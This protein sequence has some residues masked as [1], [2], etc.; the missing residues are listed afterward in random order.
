VIFVLFFFIYRVYVQVRG[1]RPLHDQRPHDEAAD[2][3]AAPTVLGLVAASLNTQLVH[4]YQTTTQPGAAAAF[5]DADANGDKEEEGE[6]EEDEAAAAAAAGEN[7]NAAAGNTPVA[8]ATT[9]TRGKVS[10]SALPAERRTAAATA[11]V[12][13]GRTG[14]LL[15]V[16]GAKGSSLLV[17]T[18]MRRD[19]GATKRNDFLCV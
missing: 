18:L 6:G 3:T 4:A 16:V 10:F 7:G 5:Q 1:A 19:A 17:F 14:G 11:S 15:T 8:A 13:W 2:E 9:A 12:T